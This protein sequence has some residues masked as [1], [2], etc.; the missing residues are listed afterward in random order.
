MKPITISNDSINDIL[1]NISS[2]VYND[3]II[4]YILKDVKQKK[5]NLIPEY[6]GY[7]DEYFYK[8]FSEFNIEEFAYPRDALMVSEESNQFLHTALKKYKNKLQRKLCV[9]GNALSAMYPSGGYI[10][11]H[12]NGNAPG[13]NILFSYSLDGDGWFKYYDYSD[14]EI[15]TLYDNPGWNVKVGYYPNQK[16]EPN[17]VYWHSA[18]TSRPRTSIAFIV[19]DKDLWIS[20][21]ND[22]TN[23]KYDHDVV[24]QGPAQ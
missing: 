1:S 19:R 20:M 12:H 2:S 10:G 17:R 21:I 22:I 23:G 15:K 13:Y 14:N 24:S 9:N 5:S 4:D 11:W 7:S 8:A 16:V 18:Y 6:I 3:E